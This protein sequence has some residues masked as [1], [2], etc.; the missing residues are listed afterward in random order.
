MFITAVCVI[1]L[2]KPT[3]SSHHEPDTYDLGSTF[4]QTLCN[5]LK[6]VILVTYHN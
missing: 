4:F 6:Y 5:S 3:S 2:I 1:F